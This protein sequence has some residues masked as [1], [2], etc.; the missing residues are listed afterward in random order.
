MKR[1]YAFLL[2]VCAATPV[3]ARII[4]YAPY[5]D[6]VSRSGHHE[7]T[8]R[9]FLV[10]EEISFS[11]RELVLYD[12][13]GLDEPRVIPVPATIALLYAALY[14][15][16]KTPEAPPVILVGGYLTT[17][18]GLTWQKKIQEYWIP[19]A[20]AWDFDTGG[21]FVQ[22]LGSSILPGTDEVPFVVST[23]N[24]EVWAVPMIG[25]AILLEEQASLV[26]RNAAGTRFLIHTP[27]DIRVASPYGYRDV[28]TQVPATGH[29]TGWLTDDGSVYL[30]AARAQGRFLSFHR[31][32]RHDF[33]AGPYGSEPALNGSG[34]VFPQMASFAV[35]T[36]DFNGA[37][38]I[39]RQWNRPTTLSRHTPA[40]GLQTMWEDPSRPEVEA[41][42]A[43]ASGETV[44]I[45]VH[46]DRP[47]PEPEQPD[48]LPA[49]PALAVWKVGDPMPADY[50]E[51]YLAEQPDK[52]FVHVDVDR[53]T[54]GEPF[55]FNSGLLVTDT[56]AGD[57]SSGGGGGGDII[58]EWGVVRGSLKEHLVLPGVARTYGAH[59]SRWFTDVTI[60]NPF[61]E[62][63]NVELRF[64][65]MGEEN[66]GV[67]LAGLVLS[68]A[69]R[70]IRV[71]EDVLQSFAVEN[72]GGTLHVLATRTAN[73]TSRTYSRSAA[74]TYGFGMYAID[75]FTATGPRFPLTF[76]GAFA[77]EHFRTNVL[78]TDTSGRGAEAELRSHRGPASI[79]GGSTITAPA[80][81]TMQ[82][83]GVTLQPD[84]PVAA[85]LKGGA[86]VLET[87]R[88][89][90]IPMVIAI[91]NRTNDATYLPPDVATEARRVIPAIG[92]LDGAQGSRFRSDLYL[93]NG[94]AEESSV[95]LQAF[96][97][98]SNT[99]R[100][101]MLN[102]QP[103]ESRI[104]P[105][106]LMTLFGMTGLAQLRFQSTRSWGTVPGGVR[107]TS[108]TYNVDAAGATS[109]CLIPPFNGFNSASSEER[110]EI[111]TPVPAG[112]RVNLGLVNLETIP[113]AHSFMVEIFDEAGKFIGS[114]T[115]EMTSG[116]GVQVNNLFGS[117][118][119]AAPR[120]ARIV[121][122]GQD[123]GQMFGAYVTL[124]DNLTN[125]TLYLPAQLGAKP[126]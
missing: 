79:T 12:S 105:D 98:N 61:D 65:A 54:A 49:D 13:A 17:D 35:P 38:I 99:S 93:F 27:T 71:I 125:D 68:L 47:F 18:L 4:S 74:G 56:E 30:V 23:A 111:V 97:W 75:F 106:A 80:G 5:S 25:N 50:D 84:G 45:Q 100:E 10:I 1:L 24:H 101:V 53:L 2:L 26:G 114:L 112:F 11:S 104:I 109:G 103:H 15:P 120:A 73:V 19:L 81:G 41:L 46:R 88:G 102:M 48:Y 8:T 59:G 43:G 67:P 124:T 7:R 126:D 118:G 37:W 94:E 85:A 55:I 91:D 119:I 63:Q 70:E 22:G 116:A 115:P 34:A 78:L 82:F 39:Q 6:R 52:G 64:V 92:H 66:S 32:N 76:A 40:E 51:L 113:D 57:V 33:I 117:T 107:V 16:K 90:L 60:Y 72:G 86:L 3:A 89:T 29:Y 123:Y 96:H 77:G 110:L 121:V 122:R 87:K 36:H 9:R 62:P 108:R 20:P 14:E 69:P 58:Q 28:V 31:E 21:P 95:S 44:L 83:N 42:I